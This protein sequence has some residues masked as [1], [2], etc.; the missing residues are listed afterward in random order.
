MVLSSLS[1]HTHFLS[2]SNV[3]SLSCWQTVSGLEMFATAT[4]NFV[5]EVDEGGLLIPVSSLNDAVVPLTVVVKHKRFWCWQKPKYITTDFT[6]NDILSGDTPIQPGKHHYLLSMSVE[7]AKYPDLLLVVWMYSFKITISPNVSLSTGV[8][9]TDF[10]K[11]NGT[12][13]GNM[14]GNIETNFA[15][16]NVS[17]GSKDSSK[18][19]SVFGSLKKQEVDVQKLLR[20]SKDRFVPTLLSSSCLTG[21]VKMGVNMK[22]VHP[23][24]HLTCCLF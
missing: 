3:A 19:K 6:L 14:Q 13:G 8:R 1:L 24:Y 23:K 16:G 10:I 21:F 9:E 11:Y 22:A 2:F 18:L 7:L 12:F 5:E 17:L 15:Q 20:D 4:R